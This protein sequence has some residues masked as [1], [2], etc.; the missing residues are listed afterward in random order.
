MRCVFVCF[1]ACVCAAVSAPTRAAES[2]EDQWKALV[3]LDAGPGK[4][5]ADASGARSTAL[6]HL[7]TQ[8]VA[9]RGF[10]ADHPENA[11]AW[12]ARLRLARLLQI[13][14]N[15]SGNRK[16]LPEA[17]HLLDELEK[18]ASAE[19]RPEVDFARV[20]FFM[21][22]L[23]NPTATDRDRLLG[24][25]RRFQSEHPGD[26]RVAALLA[27]VATLFEAQPR[28]MKQLLTDARATATDPALMA[29][30]A[31]DLK[32]A[33]LV[34]E[35]MPL[36]F[37]T[38]QGKEFDLQQL[39][40]SVVLAIFFA[41]WSN[42][43]VAALD[44]VRAA[45]A[46]ISRAPFQLIALSV[47][48]RREPLV[49]FIKARNLAWPIGFDGKGWESPLIRSLGINALPAAWLFDKQGRLRSIAALEDPA[50]QVRGL[51][52]E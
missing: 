23:R 7:D 14:T 9:L 31:D 20:T 35:I 45:T 12:E 26:R 39:R 44:R 36:R 25:A 50:G 13:R 46:K 27:E 1:V 17:E 51:L 42:E 6:A 43:S 30:I 15:I 24:L 10:L 52:E 41:V 18:T 19:Q 40:G 4:G 2:A 49:A 47:D 38:V 22:S 5:A 3:A 34:G 48:A 21:R 16:Y 33:N 11:H 8:E 28:T 32:R 37:T 29:Q